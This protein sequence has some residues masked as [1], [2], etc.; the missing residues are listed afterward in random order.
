MT[1]T[2]SREPDLN[3]LREIVKRNQR[4]GT[5]QP[6][7]PN[8]QVTTDRE[9]NLFVGPVQSSP[10]L[11]KVQQDTFAQVCS[12][13]VLLREATLDLGTSNHRRG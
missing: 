3:Q 13:W 5:S 4:S 8:L 7:D 10:A 11:S 2:V 9:G 6:S 1:S 12:Q